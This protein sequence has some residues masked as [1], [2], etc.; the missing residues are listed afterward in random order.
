MNHSRSLAHSLFFLLTLSQFALAQWMQPV[1]PKAGKNAIQTA[2]SA[3]ADAVAVIAW[4]WREQFDLVEAVE[5]A[6]NAH[7]DDPKPIILDGLERELG[8]T[9]ESFLKMLGGAGY[10]VLFDRPMNAEAVPAALVLEIRASGGFQELFTTK[11]KSLKTSSGSGFSLATNGKDY[12]GHNGTWFFWTQGEDNA[13]LCVKNL[14][15]DGRSLVESTAYQ[16]AAKKLGYQKAG[17]FTFLDY[18]K[19]E[20]RLNALMGSKKASG[21]WGVGAGCIDFTTGRADGFITPGPIDAPSK[22]AMLSGGTLTPDFLSTIPPEISSF[23]AVDGAWYGRMFEASMRENPMLAVFAAAIFSE[24]NKYGSLQEAFSGPVALGT[25][26]FAVGLQKEEEEKQQTLR[27]ED[28]FECSHHIQF[29]HFQLKEKFQQ[30]PELFDLLKNHG[31]TKCCREADLEIPPCPAAQQVTYRAE[32]SQDNAFTLFCSGHH[33][34]T[35]EPDQPTAP[36]DDP[37][38]VPEYKLPPTQTKTPYLYAQAEIRDVEE[39]HK[40]LARLK[41]SSTPKSRDK[42]AENLKNIGTALEMYSIDWSG[43]YP[44]NLDKLTPNY[45]RTLPLCPANEKNVYLESYKTGPTQEDGDEQTYEV[46]CKGHQHP[47]L[48]HDR[49]YYDSRYGLE[50]GVIDPEVALREESLGSAPSEPTLYEVSDLKAVLDTDKKQLRV[51]A[52]KEI[53][54]ETVE[55]RYNNP[56][57]SGLLQETL[58]WAQGELLYLAYSDFS[59]PVSFLLSKKDLALML[60]QPEEVLRQWA[61]RLSSS[62]S[63]TL[64]AI[65]SSSQ[66][67]HYRARGVAVSAA[68]LESLVSFLSIVEDPMTTRA[69]T[70]LVVCKSNLRNLATACEMWSIDHDGRYPDHLG[71]L[72]PDYLARIPECP[73]GGRDTYSDTYSFQKLAGSPDSPPTY[74]FYCRGDHHR[75]AGMEQNKPAYNGLV[76]FEE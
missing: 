63:D 20:V 18:Q 49:P 21:V 1:V 43:D 73:A 17:L 23:F 74:R 35:P 59:S 33:H 60:P 37:A 8:V 4:N 24:A 65:R 9:P 55:E 30:T 5:V 44:P 38:E 71:Q 26:V 10:I 57:E 29:L 41:D 40:I 50:M 22:K 32:V 58:E 2:G 39:T 76:G 31:L 72:A 51:V 15:G 6:R 28:F 70:Q 14:S 52:G 42:C 25:N 36:V 16:Q 66:G 11:S 56:L 13:D 7:G 3:P 68:T 47:E 75:P 54:R 12:F 69:R 19:L 27:V 64:L 62:P 67:L 46:Y 61:E 34:P 53:R 45:L 48:E